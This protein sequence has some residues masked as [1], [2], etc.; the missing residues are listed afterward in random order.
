MVYRILQRN[1]WNVTSARVTR[2]KGCPGQPRPY[3]WG[4]RCSSLCHVTINQAKER[5]LD[6][7]KLQ[8]YNNVRCLIS[9]ASFW[10]DLFIKSLTDPDVHKDSGL[11]CFSCS[12]GPF[13]LEANY[14]IKTFYIPVFARRKNFQSFPRLPPFPT[15]FHRRIISRARP[16]PPG[17]LTLT[18][19][20]TCIWAS[21]KCQSSRRQNGEWH[22]RLH[23]G[24]VSALVA[25]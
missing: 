12:S 25:S 19:F 4:L 14:N 5:A 18:D 21:L 2:G 8:P 17:K 1:K 15:T 23:L 7:T 13:W 6:F 16:R 10:F 20:V 24:E 3:K 11:I 22:F 9:F